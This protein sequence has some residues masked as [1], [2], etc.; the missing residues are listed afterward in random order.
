M[1]QDPNDN[2]SF[3]VANGEQA[4]VTLSAVGCNCNSAAG[5]DGAALARQSSNPDVYAFAIGGDSGS[6][7]LFAGLCQFF[8]SDPVTSHY[9]VQVGGSL[10]GNFTSSSI[11]KESPEASFQLIFTIA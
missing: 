7:K 5:F 10:G 4:Q 2:S 3:T 8:Q 6:S 9:T 11:F 1:T